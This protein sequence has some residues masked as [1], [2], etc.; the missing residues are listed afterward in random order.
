MAAVCESILKHHESGLWEHECSGIAELCP[1]TSDGKKIRQTLNAIH[2]R[3]FQQPL[4]E[5]AGVAGLLSGKSVEDIG[6]HGRPE[7]G[8]GFIERMPNQSLNT[9]LVR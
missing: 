2:I 7:L 8:N 3:G 1:E 9:Y 6:G 4:R 5:W